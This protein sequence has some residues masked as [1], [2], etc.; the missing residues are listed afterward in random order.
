[1]KET[2]GIVV[3]LVALGWATQRLWSNPRPEPDSDWIGKQAPEFAEG[4]WINSPAL[5]LKALRGKVVVLEFWTFGCYNCRNT[6]PYVKQ[7]YKK[8]AGPNFEIVGIH[9]PEFDREKVLKNVQREVERLGITYPVVTDND[10]Q[11]WERYNQ[12]YWPVVYVLD[13]QGVIR[14]VHIGEGEYDET[15]RE[16]ASL[17]AGR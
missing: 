17:I 15:D 6:L 8:Y 1:M 10:Y 14:Y 3:L 2:L 4:S 7:W 9:T 5:S 11:T 12:R 16:I 13:K